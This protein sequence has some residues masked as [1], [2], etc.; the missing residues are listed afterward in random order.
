MAV[1]WKSENK[2]FLYYWVGV[3]WWGL[4]NLHVFSLALIVQLY[5]EKIIFLLRVRFGWFNALSICLCNY[6]VL[7][8]Y[9]IHIIL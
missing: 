4:E 3:M 2:V 6:I 1:K 8:V 7:L 9:R 5:T